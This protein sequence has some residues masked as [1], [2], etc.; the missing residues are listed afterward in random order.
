MNEVPGQFAHAAYVVQ[1]LSGTHIGTTFPVTKP[2]VTIGRDPSNDLVFTDPTVSRFHARIVQR[3]A[4]WTIEK[5]TEKNILKV[6]AREVQQSA[7]GTGDMVS[8]SS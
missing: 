4:L 6:N 7:L 1:V 5:V 2:I 3:G 8:L